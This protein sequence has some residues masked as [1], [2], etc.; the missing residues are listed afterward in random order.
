MIKIKIKNAYIG[1]TDEGTLSTKWSAFEA[2][3]AKYGPKEAKKVVVIVDSEYNDEG[4]DYTTKT[5]VFFDKSGEE[6][7]LKNS[8]EALTNMPEL[9]SSVLGDNGYGTGG[10]IEIQ[11]VTL[12]LE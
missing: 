5:A 4:Y 1:L 6:L 12:E 2:W 9:P 7:A 10:E 3:I 11:H 8:I